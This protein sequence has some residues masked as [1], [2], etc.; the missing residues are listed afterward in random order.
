[1]AMET[2]LCAHGSIIDTMR[3]SLS[4]ISTKD[5]VRKFVDDALWWQDLSLT[6]EFLSPLAHSIFSL[7]SDNSTLADAMNEMVKLDLWYH[8]QSNNSGAYACRK[9]A[10]TCIKQ[11]WELHGSKEGYA[12]HILHPKYRG[13]GLSA[14][15]M[16]LGMSYIYAFGKT[17]G[18]DFTNVTSFIND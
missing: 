17:Q 2:L 9:V 3:K 15:Q 10:Y 6:V 16:Q 11:R 7:E 8:D 14:K 18:D 1:M 12:A 4:Y 13:Q 5:I